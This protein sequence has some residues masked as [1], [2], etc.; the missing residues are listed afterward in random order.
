MMSGDSVDLDA[1]DAKHPATKM[2]QFM[3]KTIDFKDDGA[4]SKARPSVINRHLVS[5]NTLTS[6]AR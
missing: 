5:E 1:E 4:K 3:Q 6:Y 2:Q